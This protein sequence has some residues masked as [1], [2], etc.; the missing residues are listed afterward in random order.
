[1]LI[2]RTVRLDLRRGHVTGEDAGTGVAGSSSSHFL[3]HPPYVMISVRPG[4][5]NC[6]Y[7]GIY[8]GN[9]FHNCSYTQSGNIEDQSNIQEVWTCQLV[10][11][12]AYAFAFCVLQFAC[13]LTVRQLS[14][15]NGL[16][17]LA[18]GMVRERPHLSGS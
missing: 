18:P 8:Q 7:P 2:S 15:R 11:L 1:M 9:N 14:N 6:N 17:S 4:F 12:A 10:G 16:C 3:L 13:V 5:T